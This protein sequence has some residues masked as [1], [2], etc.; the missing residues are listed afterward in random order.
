[1]S[2][3]NYDLTYIDAIIA[4][5]LR[6]ATRPCSKRKS[7]VMSVVSPWIT[8]QTVSDTNKRLEN[9]SG[10]G[11]VAADEMRYSVRG[12][13]QDIY[14]GPTVDSP[15]TS[16]IVREDVLCNVWRWTMP[17]APGTKIAIRQVVGKAGLS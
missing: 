12:S 14:H 11:L 4:A 9:I 13:G 8:A 16:Y 1:M 15:A 3:F 2:S 5:I 10:H 6:R 17:Q 7:T